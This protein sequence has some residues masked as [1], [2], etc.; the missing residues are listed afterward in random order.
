MA[1]RGVE[2]QPQRQGQQQ[3]RQRSMEVRRQTA[4]KQQGGSRARS[5]LDCAGES[6]LQPPAAAGI[7]KTCTLA[8]L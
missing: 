5:L 3:E 6:E 8:C 7:L 2:P 4:S 1:A